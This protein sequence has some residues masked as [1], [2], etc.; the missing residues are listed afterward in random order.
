MFAVIYRGY[1]KPELEGQYREYW[2]I[3]A[4]YFVKERGAIGSTLHKAEEGMW[5]AYSKWPDKRTRDASWPQREEAIN[6]NLPV[7][8]H[9]AIQ[10][11]RSCLDENRLLPEICMEVQ[12][13][14]SFTPIP[15]G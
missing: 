11:L 9:E 4:A 10:G 5:I 3:V 6:P 1:V 8:V 15:R 2:K 12:E 14:I 13:E 7:E